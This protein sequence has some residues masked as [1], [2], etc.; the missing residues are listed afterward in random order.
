MGTV[1]TAHC[2]S[3]TSCGGHRAFRSRPLRAACM[4]LYFPVAWLWSQEAEVCDVLPSACCMHG[5]ILPGAA[6]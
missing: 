2:G 3:V 1:L 4:S 5:R 6:R